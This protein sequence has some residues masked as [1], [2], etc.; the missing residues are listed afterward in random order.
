MYE[1]ALT[2]FEE[3]VSF[4]LD[5]PDFAPSCSLNSV[6]DNF[7]DR[8]HSISGRSEW[9]I[10]NKSFVFSLLCLRHELQSTGNKIITI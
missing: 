10:F 6:K 2:E 7:R 9:F 3:S 8:A 1:N 5:D 4:D